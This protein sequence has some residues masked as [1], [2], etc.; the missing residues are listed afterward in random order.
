VL[1]ISTLAAYG[2]NSR[3]PFYGGMPVENVDC[4]WML[5]EI[6]PRAAPFAAKSVQFCFLRQPHFSISRSKRFGR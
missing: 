6:P 3:K 1:A 5:V 2:C 4:L